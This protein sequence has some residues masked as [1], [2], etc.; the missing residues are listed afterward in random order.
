M[1]Y[2][3]IFASLIIFS[4][5]FCCS[6]KEKTN[7]PTSKP[8]LNVTVVKTA[9]VVRTDQSAIL[10]SMGMLYSASEV[11][12]AFKIGGVIRNLNFKEGE[13][14]RKGQLIAVLDQTEINAQL[15][16]AKL[17][18]QKAE[19]DHQRVSNLFKD[20]VSTLEQLQNALSALDLAK[21]QFQI[22]AFNQKYASIY[23]PI[24]GQIL[25][26]ISNEGELIGPGQP[27]CILLGTTSKEWQVK[28]GLPE[29]DWAS[30]SIGDSATI[31]LEAY[32]TLLIHSIVESKS[33]ATLNS[34]GN[35]DVT[36]KPFKMPSNVAAGMLANCKIIP[37][38]KHPRVLVPIEAL[39][40]LDG[41][42]ASVF[43]DSAGYAQKIPVQLKNILGAEAELIS[44][45]S[46]I[47][48]L[49]TLG[50]SYLSAGDKI[51]LAK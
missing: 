15:A 33:S 3:N 49:I 13:L 37:T 20:S 28:S 32:P 10:S 51:Q 38:K 16:Q 41:M 14:I 1:K 44:L 4:A 29:K 11:K 31:I 26:K 48:E 43:I 2:F 12:A 36:L 17:A 21:Q 42:Q 22:A 5:L 27:V 23:A 46:E 9:P 50:A 35:F 19:R 30:V 8:D 45:N 34:N 7:T 39:V 47:R 25:K 24:D 18:L 40:E 6:G